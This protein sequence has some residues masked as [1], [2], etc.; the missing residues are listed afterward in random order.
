[1]NQKFF[2]ERSTTP[3]R[4]ELDHSLVEEEDAYPITLTLRH[5][6]KEAKANASN[7]IASNEGNVADEGLEIV[8]AKYLVGADGA[9]S[10]TRKQLNIPLE[11]NQTDSVW[12][13]MDI[14]PLTDFRKSSAC[15][16]LTP[17]L[18]SNPQPTFVNHA[19]S[20]L[21]IMAAS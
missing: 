7:G 20:T 12:G 5:I 21:Q 1:M 15:D 9:K 19:R 3:E 16:E 4:L 6:K 8:K 14:I 11:G 17:L 2:V 10:W 13:V 18:T